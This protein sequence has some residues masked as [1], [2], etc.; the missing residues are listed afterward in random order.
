MPSRESA[1][2]V[3]MLPA[4]WVDRIFLKLQT[5]YGSAWLAKWAGVDMQAVRNDW[6]EELAGFSRSPESIRHAL[7]HLPERPPSVTDFKAMCNAAP[8]PPV[9]GLL[10]NMP[11]RKPAPPDIAA[12]LAAFQ[13]RVRGAR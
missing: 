8:P 10:T 13:T 9:A 7:E 2:V 4:T 3:A 12:K 5:R 1:E 11:V 6:A